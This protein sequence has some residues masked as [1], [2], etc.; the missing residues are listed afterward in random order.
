MKISLD[1]DET[2]T[3]DPKLW[4]LFVRL[5][6]ARG[7]EVVCVTMRRPTEP[8]EFPPDLKIETVYTSRQGKAEFMQ[9]RGEWVD[10]WI[11]DSPCWI[12][13]SAVA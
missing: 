12:L 1:Y 5:A 13:E 3:L 11:D 9:K 8:T 10:I 4:E 7:H 6:V 2:Y